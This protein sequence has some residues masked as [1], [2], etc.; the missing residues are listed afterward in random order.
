M[1]SIVGGVAKRLSEQ[2]VVYQGLIA[3]RDEVA[4]LLVCAINS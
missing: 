4:N 2:N 3:H 1:F